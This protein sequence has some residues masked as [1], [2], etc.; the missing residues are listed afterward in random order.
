M[1]LSPSSVNPR[2]TDLVAGWPK[3]TQ[4]SKLCWNRATGGLE[5]AGPKPEDSERNL[6][7]VIAVC[8]V[9][10]EA[11]LSTMKDALRTDKVRWLRSQNAA[12]ERVS[13]ALLGIHII[14]DSSWGHVVQRAV[15]VGHAMVLW[16][17]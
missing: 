7:G 6:A 4:L 11:A 13:V 9:G 15:C 12:E 10:N 3:P 16:C 14:L 17:G 8:K 1:S 2:M 5:K